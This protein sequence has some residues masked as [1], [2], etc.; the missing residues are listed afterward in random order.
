MFRQEF[1]MSLLR[2]NQ[3]ACFLSWQYIHIQDNQADSVRDTGEELKRR[4]VH[5]DRKLKP[6]SAEF[7]KKRTSQWRPI[8][9]FLFAINKN[10]IF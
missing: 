10:T 4:L 1:L 3:L 9:S 2:L 7:L 5:L 8:S 6:L